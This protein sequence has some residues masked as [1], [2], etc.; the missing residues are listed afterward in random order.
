M[1][2]RHDVLPDG[3][4]VR[5]LPVRAYNESFFLA[6]AVGALYFMRRSAWWI[7][8]V[9]GGFASAHPTGRRPARLGVRRRVPAAAGLEIAR[10]PDRCAA[11]CL[12]CR[13]AW[14][15]SSLYA[16]HPFG[17][18]LKF[19]HVQAAWGRAVTTLD[20]PS[21]PF[22]SWSTRPSRR[23]IFQ[24]LVGAQRDR[25]DLLRTGHSR[26]L[27]LSV[28]GRWKLGPESWY[29]VVFSTISFCV[30]LVSP[31]AL[32][33]PDARPSPVPIED[34]TRPSWC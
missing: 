3:V 11:A 6:L 15:C 5:V 2:R 8:G 26:L 25:H 28:V 34:G 18:P 16:W 21:G 24:P 27:V 31:S 30:V 9:L 1:A 14:R 17:D 12:W 22:K 13:S 20:G 10:D 32:S 33:A 23:Y 4:P 7:A 29:L 19:V